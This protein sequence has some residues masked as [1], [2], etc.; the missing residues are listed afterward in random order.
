MNNVFYPTTYEGL[1]EEQ[2]KI[3]DKGINDLML[4]S[5]R[6]KKKRENLVHSIDFSKH[7]HMAPKTC[8]AWVKEKVKD[9]GQ[10]VY[11]DVYKEISIDKFMRG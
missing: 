5:I 6:V 2:K 8:G 1:S 9:K 3:N 7:P 4:I 10:W 11:K